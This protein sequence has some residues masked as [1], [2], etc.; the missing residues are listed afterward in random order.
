MNKLQFTDRELD[1]LLAALG[2]AIDDRGDD[3]EGEWAALFDKIYRAL[4]STIE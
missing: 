3:V 1:F 4:P 2:C